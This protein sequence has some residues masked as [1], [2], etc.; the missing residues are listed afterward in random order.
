MT[1]ESYTV[2][3]V[4][5]ARDGGYSKAF[6]DAYST[7]KDFTGHIDQ[8][9]TK[10]KG[11]KDTMMGMVAATAVTTALSTAWGM[12][13]DSV[14]KAMGRIDTMN[15]FKR[16][17]QLMTSDT[18]AATRA[19]DTLKGAS[20]GTAYGL[21]VMAAATQRFVTASY[22]VDKSTQYVEG[23][24]NAVAMYGDGSNA[25]FERVM[26]QMGQMAAKG[27][28]NMGDIKS[29]MEAGIPVMQIYAQQMGMTRDEVDKAMS[30]GQI[31][32]EEF[33]AAM[34]VAFKNGTE[35]FPPLTNAA[36]NAGSSWSGTFSNMKAATTRGMVSIIES[37]ETAR[38][39]SNL[40][41]MQD[42]IKGFGEM[43]ESV[44]NRAGEVL[45][46]LAP[47]F[48]TI[49][50]A[51]GSMFA[52]FATHHIIT[53]AVASFERFSGAVK[54]SN[55]IIGLVTGAMKT[56]ESV[57][58]TY[59]KIIE[60]TA[61]S[62]QIFNAAKSVG[63]ALNEKDLTLKATGIALT[64]EEQKQIISATAAMSTKGII[65]SVLTG[66]ITIATAA[67]LLWNKV[68]M[69]NP[70]ILFVTLIAGLVASLVF[71]NNVLN[72][73]TDEQKAASAAARDH[74]NAMNE[75]A[76]AS[77]NSTTEYKNTMAQIDGNRKAA[78]SYVSRLKEISSS[79]ESSEKKSAQLRQTL[80][81]LKQLYPD[82][83]FEIDETTGSIVGGTD[84]IVSQLDATDE[85]SKSKG[86]VDYINQM[87]SDQE[88]LRQ[89]IEETTAMIEAMQ[90]AGTDKK[91]TWF[92]LGQ[93]DTDEFTELKASLETLTT[94][95]DD[96]TVKIGE[97]E[98][99]YKNLSEAE[100]QAE[101]DRREHE[102]S[103]EALSEAYG[104]TTDDIVAYSE[105]TGEALEDAGEKVV[106]LADKFGMSTDEVVAAAEYYGTTLEG[107]AKMHEEQLKR[108]EE[109][110]NK[111]VDIVSD[112]WSSL[113]QK[114][115]ISID[116]YIENLRNNQSAVE[117][118]AV[119]VEALMEAGVDRGVL[120]NLAK[121]GPAGAA[122][123][124]Q[125]VAELEALNN[126][127][128]GKFDE[129]TPAAQAKIEW[130]ATTMEQG[131]EIAAY[132]AEVALRT[133][134]DYAGAAA[135]LVSEMAGG[136]ASA[137]PDLTEQA[138]RTG[139]QTFDAI[140]D[141][142]KAD[143]TFKESGYT[144]GRKYGEQLVRGLGAYE[145]SV[146]E[147]ANA[148]AVLTNT[149]LA[150]LQGKAYTAGV[151]AGQGLAN[152]LYAKQGA[153]TSAATSLAAIAQNTIRSALQIRS[154]SKVMEKLGEYT[155]EGQAVG[156]IN[157]LDQVKRAA[158]EVGF[159]AIPN[160]PD[161]GTGDV[162]SGSSGTSR[163]A[164]P[165]QLFLRMGKHVFTA[166]AE[167]IQQAQDEA[168]ELNLSYA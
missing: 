39:D 11:F 28:A 60:T 19:L 33:F 165:M 54:A 141:V 29:A 45:S 32:A 20:R 109:A 57:V 67:Q 95:Y 43:M 27:K 24:G 75:L 129:L 98:E 2:E 107:W 48:E 61:G 36:K 158:E 160:V 52:V 64:A 82:L 92:G 108:A 115:T 103:L 166:F 84:A 135:D 101:L 85:L 110:L 10:A 139:Q 55:D 133:G 147:Q 26:L 134:G 168:L 154:P 105:R 118:W 41:T 113:E 164:M 155:A 40:P 74:A 4:L 149:P 90:N 68:M 97:A 159:A 138:K 79:S 121:L 6:K 77:G 16:T 42:A 96:L 106:A 152:G 120:Q 71:L 15:Q 9:N 163:F 18:E 136:I 151:N 5:T 44:M 131:L 12:V 161:I 47:H 51:A 104:V 22:D 50:T 157:R 125:F 116:K 167:D 144:A 124:A 7:V 127:A 37:I 31:S 123:A 3:A 142:T 156:M 146:S 72:R 102:R 128:L 78:E 58:S 93:K 130:L 14:S 13:K 153:V 112:G 86:M 76:D 132:G 122:Q 34:D 23:W 62:E 70:I 145:R 83:T 117:K 99:E 114:S 17:I 66:K 143:G 94:S 56:G 59:S 73:Q 100:I 140:D 119:N 38:K 63:I 65:M 53:S 21:D 87:N 91:K 137:T 1:S 162:L 35:S 69:A 81:N 111:H 150:D 88:V 49:A 126:G 25:T 89:K 148:L 80:A 8:S 46:A 30:A